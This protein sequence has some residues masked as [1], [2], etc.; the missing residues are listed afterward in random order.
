MTTAA[1]VCLQLQQASHAG[2][3]N[4]VGVLV[5]SSSSALALL[6]EQAVLSLVTGGAEC[7]KQQGKRQRTLFRGGRLFCG[8][9]R[10]RVVMVLQGVETV[11]SDCGA[12]DRTSKVWNTVSECVSVLPTPHVAPPFLQAGVVCNLHVLFCKTPFF[13]TDLYTSTRIRAGCSVRRA[14]NLGEARWSTPHPC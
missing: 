5:S 13:I 2:S 7:F 12:Q 6:T 4:S 3:N 10:T 9:H 8:S 11:T 1:G 14:F